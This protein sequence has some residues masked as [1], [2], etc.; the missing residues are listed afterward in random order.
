MRVPPGPAG[1]ALKMNFNLTPGSLFIGLVAGLL[2]SAYFMYGKRRSR[3]N[4]MVAGGLLLVYPYFVDRLIW[5]VLLGAAIA[6]A[7]FFIDF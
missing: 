5:Q 4:L 6:A 3:I 2:G 7:P 1:G